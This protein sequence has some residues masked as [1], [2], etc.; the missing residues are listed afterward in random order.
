LGDFFL[1]GHLVQQV[2][3][4]VGGLQAGRERQQK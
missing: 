4:G 2:E 1:Q 3:V